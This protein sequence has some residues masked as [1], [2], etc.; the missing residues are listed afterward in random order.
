MR[1]AQCFMW[2]A[3]EDCDPPHGLD[4]F[5]ARDYR[6]VAVLRE[7]FEK[8]GFDLEMPALVGYPMNGRVQLLSGT[9]R[10]EAAKQAGIK[11]PVTVWL[12][13]DVEQS[14]GTDDW[15]TIIEDIPVGRL[16]RWEVVDGVKRPAQE[17]VVLPQDYPR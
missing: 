1:K 9:H 4:M 7:E 16:T 12:R 13:S 14:W 3:P 10:H 8:E 17:P 2:I 6:K 11:L 15:L 5:S